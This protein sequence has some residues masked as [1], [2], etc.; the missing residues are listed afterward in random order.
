MT[1]AEHGS[2]PV[3]SLRLD[4]LAFDGKPVLGEV[5]LDL[6]AGETLVI[7]GPS[8]IGKTSLLRVLA[9]LETGFDGTLTVPG[10]RSMVFQEPTLLPWRDLRQNLCLATGISRDAADWA[11]DEVGLGGLGAR[12][13]GQLSLGQQ[14]RLSL[15]RAFAVAPDVLLM[16][17]PFVSLDPALV[18]EM[19][20]LFERLRGDRNV[21]TVLVTHVMAEA[22]RLGS[23][24]VTLKG[25]PAV[26]K[27]L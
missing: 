13:P 19:M 10:R 11:L 21:A 4:G 23:R 25:V 22:Q 1:G 20:A 16:D 12:F 24:I 3:L 26:L 5:A 15:A 6:H 27:D 14:R 2:A 18:D 7:T 8:G 9:G 17:E